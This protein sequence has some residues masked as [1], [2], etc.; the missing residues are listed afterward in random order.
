M[1]TCK[2][3]FLPAKVTV[4]VDPASYPYGRTG[5]PGSLLD[6]ALTHGVAIE[7]DCGGAGVCGTCL[8]EVQAGM[9]N[10][11]QASDEEMDRVQASPTS[12]LHSRLACQA[13]VRGDVTVAVANPQ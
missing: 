8:V 11:S 5:E 3:T 1:G 13:V 4:E 6:I 9:E 12:T 2:V 7:H 10:L